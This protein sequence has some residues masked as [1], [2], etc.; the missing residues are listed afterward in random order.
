[1]KLMRS[2]SVHLSFLLPITCAMTST[3]S[4][5]VTPGAAFSL[6]LN[7][8][9]DPAFQVPFENAVATWQS[10]IP[11]YINGNVSGPPLSGLTI[12]GSVAAIDGAGGI[13]GSAGITAGRFDNGGFFLST[14]G[15]IS[16]DVDDFDSSSASSLLNFE[17]VALHEI[18]HVLGIGIL[19]EINGLYDSGAPAVVDTFVRPDGTVFTDT[20]GQYTGAEGV[21]AY[22]AEFGEP[23]ATFVPVEKDG[24]P[25]TADAHWNEGSFGAAVGRVSAITGED[26]NGEVLTGF[27]NGS[28]YISNVTRGGLRDL[29]FDVALLAVP[30]PSSVFLLFGGCAF[31]GIRR[32][33]LVA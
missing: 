14:A 7:Y 33:R 5:Q 2:L 16:F 20:V 27:S 24:G 22:Q 25:G 3:S 11:N 32:R 31:L 12:N 10:I 21:A 15:A 8:S 28:H 23:T 19:W 4:A 9:G 1:M 18:G 26:I 17:R 29:G 13:L 6:N 30:E